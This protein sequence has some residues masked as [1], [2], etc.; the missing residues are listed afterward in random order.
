MIFSVLGFMAKRAKVS[1]K[2]VVESGSVTVSVIATCKMHVK[3][4]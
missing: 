2:D 1:V 4:Y 3:L